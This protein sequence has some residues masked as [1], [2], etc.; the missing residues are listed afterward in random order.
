[1]NDTGPP[2]LVGQALS[3]ANRFP[4]ILL[5][6]A[7]LAFAVGMAQLFGREYATGETYPEY[8]SLRA[9][10]E[11]GKLLFD[12]L[13]R[14]PGVN[15]ERNYLPIE[16]SDVR[17]ATIFILGVAPEDL[18]DTDAILKPIEKLAGRGNRIVLGLHYETGNLK[19]EALE[20]Q[21]G[22]RYATDT[23]KTHTRHLY[24]AE[25][26]GW[27]AMENGAEKSRAVER[28]FGA[29]SVAMF[30]DSGVF[31]NEDIAATE[32]LALVAAAVGGNTRV[33]FDE[34]HFGI[35]Q[36][37]SVVGLARRFRLTGLA[38]GLS[39]W[40]ALWI[41]KNAAG[42]PPPVA[43]QSGPLLGR[44]SQAGLVTLLRSH[45][46]PEAL[47]GICWRTWLETNQSVITQE[48]AGQAEAILR[49]AGSRPLDAVRRIQAILRWKGKP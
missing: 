39:I 30:A 28:A 21:W 38:V 1:M 2:G 25:A 47:A 36:A 31:A 13:A 32:R 12:S 48:Q 44:T 20:K 10:P 11:G 27:N 41:W 45:I 5:A 14:V 7:A 42:F 18:D 26:K 29:G 16:F 23:D 6:L 19:A 33:I 24:F 43:R 17:A 35:A 9:G 46:P 3:P 40:A 34:Q 4:Y 22:V 8:S 15:V 49:D 37:G